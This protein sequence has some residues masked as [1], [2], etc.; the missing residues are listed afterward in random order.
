MTLICCQWFGV[1]LTPFGNTSP[2]V[3]TSTLCLIMLVMHRAIRTSNR[4]SNYISNHMSNHVCG[5]CAFKLWKLDRYYH[6]NN[7]TQI[8]MIVTQN[9]FWSIK[10]HWETY[11][12]CTNIIPSKNK[13]KT[14]IS[15]SGITIVS[16]NF[17]YFVQIK[18]IPI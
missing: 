16:R 10:M 4:I 15:I 3:C 13:T 11:L 14:K 6:T 12:I 18:L 5:E 7:P 9:Y 2:E 1:F 8:L 17:W